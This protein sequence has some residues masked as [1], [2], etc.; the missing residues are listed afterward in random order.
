M[1]KEWRKDGERDSLCGNRAGNE[2][3]KFRSRFGHT[4]ASL[5]EES[6]KKVRRKSEEY[7]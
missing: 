2:M 7:P 4:A 1:E 5:S 6:P 3:L